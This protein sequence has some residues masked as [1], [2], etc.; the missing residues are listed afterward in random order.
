MRSV[1]AQLRGRRSS[2]MAGRLERDGFEPW[3]P[4]G[5]TRKL[6]IELLES[7]LPMAQTLHPVIG[8]LS[9][10]LAPG[11]AAVRLLT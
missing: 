5:E 2:V 3:G 1:A 8:L 11:N 4:D 9:M 7:V 10:A 6:A